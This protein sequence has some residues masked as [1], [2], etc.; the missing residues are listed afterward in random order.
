MMRALWSAASGMIAQQLRVDTIANNLAN[1]NTTGFKRSRVDFQDMLY[2]TLRA[3]GATS[4]EGVEVPTGLQIGLG[5]RLVATQQVFSPG[6]WEQTENPLDLAIRGKGFFQ[7]LQPSGSVAYTRAGAFKLDSEGT[8][9][10]SDGLPLE[11]PMVIPGNATDV[12]VGLDGTVSVGV[13]GQTDRQVLGQIELAYF[14]NPA[15][16]ESLGGGLYRPTAA[17]GEVVTG[18][19]GQDG[20][21]E[22]Q[23]G[24]VELSNVQVVQ[25]L[26][27]MIVAQRAYEANS[28]AIQVADDMLQTANNARV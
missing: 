9:V 24:A 4:A 19:P 28:R 17:S 27:N 3:P 14:P 26:V 6:V 15:G 23:S 22:V 5:T 16:L 12:W 2:Q 11:P 8:L 10:N 7:I 25:E 20:L 13:P 18:T 21:G 1:V